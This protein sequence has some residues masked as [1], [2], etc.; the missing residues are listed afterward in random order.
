MLPG[1]LVPVEDE[2]S[3][4]GIV[5]APRLFADAITEASAVARQSNSAV[6]GR[7]TVS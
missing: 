4:T 7:V 5:V 1:L 2:A 3:S 6:S